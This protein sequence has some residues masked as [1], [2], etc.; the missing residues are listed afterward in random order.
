MKYFV[1]VTSLFLFID[2]LSIVD[3]LLAI[4]LETS[5]D[6]APHPLFWP[7]LRAARGK[8]TVSDIPN[9]LIYCKI[10]YYVHKLKTWLWA[11]LYNLVGQLQLSGRWLETHVITIPSV[12]YVV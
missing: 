1:Y 10:L 4:G 5:F 3:N 11:A 2:S 12:L 9:C 6:I 7:G 8:V